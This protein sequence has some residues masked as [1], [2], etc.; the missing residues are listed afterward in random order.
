MNNFEKGKELEDKS[1]DRLDAVGVKNNKNSGD[2]IDIS[3]EAASNE[4]AIQCKNWANKIG[5]N[6]VD[7]LAGVL[8]KREN[9][10]KIG[11]VVA[12]SGYQRKPDWSKA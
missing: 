4:F 2:G 11:I 1:A 10:D 5:H 9:R 7:E 3:G 6:V 12:P 8:S